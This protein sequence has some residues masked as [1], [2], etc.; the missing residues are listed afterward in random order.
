MEHEESA[1][2]S[3]SDAA[4]QRGVFDGFSGYV[5]PTEDDWKSVLRDG[6]VVI[7]TNVLLNLYRYN[8]A[9]RETFM[10]TL[11]SLGSCLW[12]PHQVMEEF[13][14]NR[15]SAIEDPQKQLDASAAAL[16]K[17]LQKA[18]ED[19]RSWTNRVSLER[20]NV[21]ELES[22]LSAA[23]DQ[24]IAAMAEVV[25][26]GEGEMSHDTSQDKVVAALDALLKGK[27]GPPL[28]QKDLVEQIAEGKRRIQAQV[29]PGYK[30]KAKASRGDNSEV[31][32]YL[33]WLQLIRE[34]K[35]RGVD[36]LLV[37]GD[38][39]E[40]WW[41]TRNNI[42]VGPR[43]ELAEELRREAGVRLYMLKPDKLLS[44]ARDF[45][46][47][48][49]TED[50]VQNVEMV[51]AQ[52][53]SDA[54]F[55][56]LVELAEYDATGAVLGAWRE[57]EG[58]LG[59]LVPDGTFGQRRVTPGMR[60]KFLGESYGGSSDVMR[61]VREL[62]EIRNQVV[63]SSEI[64]LTQEGA[65]AFVAKAKEVSDS[66]A[67]ASAP[68]SQSMRL[69]YAIYEALNRRGFTVTQQQAGRFQYDFL[70]TDDSRTGSFVAVEAKFVSDGLFRD[71]N[72]REEAGKLASMPADVTSLLVVTN[73]SLV[74]RVQEFNATID[75]SS[76]ID[77]RR[78]EVVQWR[79]PDDDPL[80]TRALMRAMR[81]SGSQ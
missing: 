70:V 54:A 20:S 75:E 14:R 56:A 80:L 35:G 6:L 22:T 59:R 21:E 79:G 7:D 67:L 52:S 32:D 3:E 58:A 72:L 65:R 13:W 60:L 16:K 31:G 28:D 55:R 33:V 5:T 18:V 1:Q 9:A 4:A 44:Y 19:L 36:V 71:R 29:P 77:G 48:E 43:N 2:A 64:E 10:E 49:V 53:T 8:Q 42:P 25:N 73:G 27:V 78:L 76:G 38:T 24:V 37:T 50:S 47:V 11:Q 68:R 46:Q 66:L 17:G 61:R 39:K 45:L 81:K 34:A 12:V 26:G 23:F 40:D 15:E 57:V 74:P 62:Q 51:A 63:H 69:E 30:D 41:R